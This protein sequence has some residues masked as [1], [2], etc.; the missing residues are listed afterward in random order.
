MGD[1][2]DFSE[3]YHKTYY[4]IYF[5]LWRIRKKN[6]ILKKSMSVLTSKEPVP[7]HVQEKSSQISQFTIRSPLPSLEVRG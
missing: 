3:S 4:E 1:A 6:Y 7:T 2:R 5:T